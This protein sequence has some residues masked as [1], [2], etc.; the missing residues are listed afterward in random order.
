MKQFLSLSIL[1]SLLLTLFC[2]SACT[3]DNASSSGSTSNTKQEGMA[4]PSNVPPPV[5]RQEG[6]VSYRGFGSNLNIYTQRLSEADRKVFEAFQ[7]Q[8]N[9]KVTAVVESDGETLLNMIQNRGE[10]SPAD[11]LL[12]MDA[13]LL[14]KAIYM[15]IVMPLTDQT[16]AANIPDQYRDYANHW[17][18]ISKYATVIAYA[19]DRVDASKL[20]AYTDLAKA[21]WKGRLLMGSSKDAA[22]QSLI[23]SLVAHNGAEEAQK[24]TAAVYANLARPASGQDMNQLAGLLN[25]DGDV[26]L[27]GTHSVGAFLAQN[28]SAKDKIGVVFAK[29][30][31]GKTQVNIYG[32]ALAQH[33][34]NIGNAVRMMHFLSGEAIQ[35]QLAASNFM[36]PTNPKATTSDFLQS[37]GSFEED[38]LPLDAL[39][40]N[41]QAAYQI[42]RNIGWE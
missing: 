33:A 15:G 5:V 40:N 42:L 34:P 39:G 29:N 9:V 41:N 26:A 21:D 3:S 2:F 4:E 20:K 8:H 14:W 6:N 31:K 7:E 35:P 24:W 1:V 17:S 38:K 37:W 22:F 16:I 10:S 32:M 11:L 27:V 30:S 25:S 18:A 13:G 36:Y 19:K 12:T 28:P 23:A